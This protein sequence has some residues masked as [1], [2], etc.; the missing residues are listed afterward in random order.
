M[1]AGAPTRALW[2]FALLGAALTLALEGLEVVAFALLA[3]ALT[4]VVLT[5]AHSET[6]MMAA[7]P[8]LIRLRLRFIATIQL[9]LQSFV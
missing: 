1:P 7:M 4:L 8:M 5:M 3:T 9:L 2:A 6:S